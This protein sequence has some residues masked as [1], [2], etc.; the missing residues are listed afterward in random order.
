MPDEKN[1]V[2]DRCGLKYR[3]LFNLREHMRVKHGEIKRFEYV[4]C[5]N[6]FKTTYSLKR[7]T[8]E[9]HN[10]NWS[11]CIICNKTFK[12]PR[13]LNNH[14]TKQLI[15]YF[16]YTYCDYPFINKVW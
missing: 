1:H 15:Y 8:R 10:L 7:H 6:I 14:Q 12:N 11:K 5:G 4:Q 9:V 3:Y 16:I 2:C 13:Y